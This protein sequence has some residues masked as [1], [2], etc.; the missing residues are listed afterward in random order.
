MTFLF[1]VLGIISLKFITSHL[2][3]MI[4][5][6]MTDLHLCR[7]DEKAELISFFYELYMKSFFSVFVDRKFPHIVNW[8]FA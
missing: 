1:V 8:I 6:F 4:N 3:V 7:Y 2:S 5:T